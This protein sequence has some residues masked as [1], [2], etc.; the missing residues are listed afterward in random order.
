MARRPGIMET[1]TAM[2]RRDRSS[3][4]TVAGIDVGGRTKGFHVVAMRGD[5][6][7]RP[8][9]RLLE[10]LEVAAWCRAQAV[11]V[12][13]IDAPCRW[14]EG[15]MARAAER[16]LARAR[17]GS[18]LTPT[19]ASAEVA[20]KDFYGWMF[21]GEALYA[22][23]AATHP[24][25]D[26]G[27]DVSAGCFCFETFPHAIACTLAGRILKASDKRADRQGV[28]QDAGIDVGRGAGI[29][30]IDAALCALVA[31][32]LADGAPCTRFGDAA[33][34]WIVVPEGR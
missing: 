31:R 33:T 20:R 21:Q 4:D 15:G 23:L 11:R 25:L 9:R 30:W 29:D 24:L 2:T 10:A 14:R 19:R 12:I 17:I 6:I 3:T 13:G 5:E 28:L 8:E 18:F 22:A 7:L 34:G 26:A 16:A 1:P 32:R 27:T